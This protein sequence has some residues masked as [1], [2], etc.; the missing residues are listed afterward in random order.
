MPSSPSAEVRRHLVRWSVIAGIVV[1]APAAA[2][3]TA[4]VSA[5]E[6]VGTPTASNASDAPA[7]PAASFDVAPVVEM[8]VAMPEPGAS[9]TGVSTTTMEWRV[10]NENGIADDNYGVV[11]E[12]FN[13]GVHRGELSSEARVDV[14]LF[15]FRPDPRYQNLN[16][17]ERLSV[18]WAPSSWTLTAGDF[19][20]QVGRG[21]LLSLRKLNEAGVDV[22]LRG[23]RVG[24]QQGAHNVVAFGGTTNTVNIDP[25]N[26]RFLPD[27]ADVVAGGTWELDAASWLKVGAH[28]VYTQP[29][30]SLLPD[31]VDNAATASVGLS[32]P[33]IVDVLSLQVETAVQARS[34]AGSSRQGSAIS[35]TSELRLGDF[36]VIGEGLLLSD[37]EQKGSQNAVLGNRFDYNQPPTLE[38]IDQEVANNRDLLGLRLRP[39]YFFF[40]LDLLVFLNGVYRW[41]EPDEPSTLHQ[42]HGYGGFEWRMPGGASRLA[43]TVGARDEVRAV[44]PERE[45][46]RSMVH[47][48]LDWLQSLGEDFAFHATSNTQWWTFLGDGFVRGSTLV[49]VERAGQGGLT[50]EFGYDTQNKTPGVRT[51][52]HALIASAEVGDAVLV[53]GTVGT[54]RGGIK[55]VAGVCREFPAFAGGRAEVIVRW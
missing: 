19:Y 46:L 50:Y 51:L 55:C 10:D 48:D 38:R 17:I 31:T 30:E 7:E 25:I 34:L 35:A 54:Q 43:A 5:L 44:L 40:D 20:Q 42:F 27:A 45:P 29:R 2:Q 12:R 1:A 39:E 53:R 36:A 11:L 52:F 18:T 21:L 28:A 16:Q 23:G 6:V 22:A 3:D 24:Y 37:F 32:M 13:F 4:A 26:Q 41:N 9:A 49:G 15:A 33:S 8:P 47:A 14:A